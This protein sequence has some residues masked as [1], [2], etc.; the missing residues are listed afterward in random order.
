MGLLLTTAFSC[1]GL[2]SF[3]GLTD[4]TLSDIQGSGPRWTPPPPATATPAVS[5][6]VAVSAAGESATEQVGAFRSSAQARNMTSSR[7]RIRQTPGHLGKPSD[8]I[9]AVIP[10]GDVVEILTGPESASNLTWW[11]VRYG[12][13]EG[14][15]AEATSS[16]VQ[17]LGRIQ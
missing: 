11:R 7:V 2:T 1:G 16:G 4:I 15:V 10:P 8:D 5:N 9:V 6:A 13:I 12:A 17:I 3:L 14:W